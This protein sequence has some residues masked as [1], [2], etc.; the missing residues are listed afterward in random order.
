[1]FTWRLSFSIA[2]SSHKYYSIEFDWKLC[3]NMLL[4][5]V[6]FCKWIQA[7]LSQR[8]NSKVKLY[9]TS[10]ISFHKQCARCE[11]TV[12]Q[13]I[14]KHLPRSI[15]IQREVLFKARSPG[16]SLTCFHVLIEAARVWCCKLTLSS[17][18]KAF[19]SLY[20]VKTLMMTIGQS[21]TSNP[22]TVLPVWDRDL[23]KMILTLIKLNL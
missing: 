19:I 14:L 20:S 10:L 23:L 17:N 7:V 22:P 5:L 3:S 12:L 4:F 11:I 2:S 15:T 6:N 13:K 1:M 21:D 8:I 9:V 16:D 18:L